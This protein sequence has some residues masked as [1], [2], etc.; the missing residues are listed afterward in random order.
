MG[1]GGAGVRGVAGAEGSWGAAST[2]VA[3]RSA[4]RYIVVCW[5]GR[6]KRA[7]PSARGK[8]AAHR[9]HG[10]AIASTG[11]SWLSKRRP[12]CV[13]VLAFSTLH[14]QQIDAS[15]A[16]HPGV[17][18]AW[19]SSTINLCTGNPREPLTVREERV[20]PRKSR[21]TSETRRVGCV[22]QAA[23]Q[24]SARVVLLS[25][26]EVLWGV[27]RMRGIDSDGSG[28]SL[29]AKLEIDPPAES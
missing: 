2:A 4:E 3:N 7:D 24:L 9:A 16:V 27:V 14:Y 17:L 28:G 15:I 13:C 23:V 26:D 22:S 19:V 1:P 29:P 21:R 5:R 8:W 25:L 6:G 12:S 10:D 20:G 18:S 11:H